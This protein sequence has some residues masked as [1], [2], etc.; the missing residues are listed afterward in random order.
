MCSQ[1]EEET[2]ESG[3]GGDGG[4]GEGDY[5]RRRRREYKC[6]LAHIE[7]RKELLQA[8]L[9][10]RDAFTNKQ[11]LRRLK[12]LEK[13]RAEQ[14]S[15]SAAAATAV[16]ADADVGEAAE[17][18]VSDRENGE[19]GSKAQF[20]S[21]SGVVDVDGEV[22]AADASRVASIALDE[23][24]VAADHRHDSSG[25][26][27]GGGHG[28]G[29]GGGG[30]R[31]GEER[32]CMPRVGGSGVGVVDKG[33]H[34]APGTMRSIEEGVAGL[35]VEG[36]A[37]GTPTTDVSPHAMPSTSVGDG[38]TPEDVDAETPLAGIARCG[39]HLRAATAALESLLV[40]EA[41]LER[42]A[43]PV[44]PSH[45]LSPTACETPTARNRSLKEEEEEEILG[46]ATGNTKR[47]AAAIK[48][49][50]LA[51]AFAFEA[52]M[53]LHLL[54]SSPHHHVHFRHECE[55][56]LRA[57]LALAREAERACGVIEC[58]D[59]LDT[60]RYLLRFSQISAEVGG[61]VP[62]SVVL[63]SRQR[64]KVYEACL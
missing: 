14:A 43:L 26:D 47:V 61:G 64:S 13:R 32:V 11:R 58:E 40:M 48:L 19:P 25:G 10:L 29:G 31:D 23:R 4:E 36:R 41:S 18:L 17:G 9:A 50:D 51:G 7:A 34:A 28:G 20:L 55:D 22:V 42:G 37:A 8:C 27:G 1:I 33:V 16:A 52:E 5:C 39:G 53:N 54:G 35:A 3:T 12:A 15:Q 21:G 24:G 56:G 49:G 44:G 46:A 30:E 6:I 60:R 38:A 57:L 62:H 45:K 2:G 63:V 59:L